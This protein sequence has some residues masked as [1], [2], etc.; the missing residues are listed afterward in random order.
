MRHPPYQKCLKIYPA[1]KIRSGFF[2]V[3]NMQGRELEIRILRKDRVFHTSV[4]IDFDN[5]QEKFTPPKVI[6]F[7]RDIFEVIE[8][9]A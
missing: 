9:L 8:G 6:H 4:D 1:R 3:W 7:E 5:Y 2:V